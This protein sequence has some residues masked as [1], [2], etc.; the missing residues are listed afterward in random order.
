MFD[1]KVFNVYFLLLYVL[2][3]F[4]LVIIQEKFQLK[5]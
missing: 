1:T 3:S 2:L 4:S 5:F